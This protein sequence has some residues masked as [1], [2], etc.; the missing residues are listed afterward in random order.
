M[1]TNNIA[2]QIKDVRTNNGWTQTEFA[3]KLHT[4]QSVVSKWE[5]GEL[6]P[7]ILTLVKIAKVAN[8]TVEELVGEETPKVNKLSE[9]AKENLLIIQ[10][11]T[12][13]AKTGQFNFSEVDF[14]NL[15]Y[16]KVTEILEEL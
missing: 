16:T 10:S 8:I 15:V 12:Y 2:K 1:K 9:D 14:V 4:Y 11:Y 13:L 6:E 3:E 5:C 7:N